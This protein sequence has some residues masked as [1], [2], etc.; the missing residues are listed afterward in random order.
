MRSHRQ[1]FRILLSLLWM[2]ALASRGGAQS[3][4]SGAIV[5][6]TFS[7]PNGTLLPNHAPDIAPSG[8]TWRKVGSGRVTRRHTGEPTAG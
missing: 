3:P 8:A 4:P 1:P 5:W 6:D 2:A 7:A